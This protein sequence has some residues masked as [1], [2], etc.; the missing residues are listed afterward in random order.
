MTTLPPKALANPHDGWAECFIPPSME[1]AILALPGFP[2]ALQRPLQRTYS[3]VDVL[4]K[5]RGMIAACEIQAGDLIIEERPLVVGPTDWTVRTSVLPSLLQVERMQAAQEEQMVH[6]ALQ[7][8]TSEYRKAFEDLLNSRE[9]G[10]SGPLRGRCKTNGFALGNIIHDDD[11]DKPFYGVFKTLSRVNHSCSPNAHYQWCTA[12]FSMQL[13]ATRRIA[14]GE[15]IL[16]SYLSDL[17]DSSTKRRETLL[18]DYGFECDCPSCHDHIQSDIR[19][20]RLLTLS[21]NPVPYRDLMWRK[22]PLIWIQAPLEVVNLVALENV[23]ACREFLK[24]LYEVMNAYAVLG[25]LCAVSR[26]ASRLVSMAKVFE[27]SSE[28]RN[29]LLSYTDAGEVKKSLHFGFG[30][31]WRK[32]LNDIPMMSLD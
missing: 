4:G 5:G 19:R 31:G 17:L 10:I 15:P 16:L 13:R 30:Q 23:Q 6:A 22:S 7:R 3:L 11:D 14:P 8:M 12:S 32:K 29:A 2:A 28:E 27:L 24:A 25:D 18:R 26:Y 20:A 9:D 1:K 21:D